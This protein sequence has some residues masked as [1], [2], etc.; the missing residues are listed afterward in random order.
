[1]IKYRSFI[2]ILTVAL[3]SCGMLFGDEKSGASRVKGQL[4]ANFSKLGLSDKQKQQIYTTQSQYR[5]RIEKLETEI[6][7]LK[8]Q[9]R[10]A[11]V[12]VLTPAQRERFKEIVAEKGSLDTQPEKKPDSK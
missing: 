12:K 9:E 3:L 4:P 7:N 11:I 10:T 8:E 1:M 6:K 5:G 2:G